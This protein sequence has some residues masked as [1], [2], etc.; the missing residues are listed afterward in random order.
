MEVESYSSVPA[1]ALA[2][3]RIAPQPPLTN[4]VAHH[5][6]LPFCQC[7]R[8]SAALVGQ[9]PTAE[10]MLSCVWVKP[11]LVVRSP[12]LEWTSNDHLRHVN[13]GG[14]REDID[15]QRVREGTWRT[16]MMNRYL[17]GAQSPARRSRCSLRSSAL[18]SAGASSAPGISSTDEL[19]IKNDE[20]RTVFCAHWCHQQ[21]KRVR[22]LS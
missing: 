22:G 13:Y 20:T 5:R 17:H 6:P 12:F 10:K 15:A 9:R 7:A 1:F 4:G 16:K 8:A 19:G 11:K 14:I 21:A 3:F 2:S 18:T